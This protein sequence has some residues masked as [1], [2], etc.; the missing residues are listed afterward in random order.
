M[1]SAIHQAC[2]TQEPQAVRLSISSNHLIFQSLV[3]LF[4]V[5]QSTVGWVNDFPVQSRTW[6]SNG[7]PLKGQ[8]HPPIHLTLREQEVAQWVCCGKSNEEIARILTISERTLKFH[9][10][11]LY[12]K[13]QISS[14]DQ[15]VAIA[16]SL[17]TEPH[18]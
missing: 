7:V 6:K 11:N 5:R 8:G 3:R 14:R 1:L 16:P 15:L 2:Q 18:S 9:L 12:L 10:K 13:L 4:P 17:V